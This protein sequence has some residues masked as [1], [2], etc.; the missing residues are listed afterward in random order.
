MRVD[1]TGRLLS[2]VAGW[3]REDGHRFRGIVR[4]QYHPK[5]VLAVRRVTR[6]LGSN[7][8]L[9]VGGLKDFFETQGHASGNSAESGSAPP[10]VKP[11]RWRFLARWF[12]GTAARFD[13]PMIAAS[14]DGRASALARTTAV[15]QE[16]SP[17]ANA[18][19]PNCWPNAKES[20]SRTDRRAI[21]PQN[22]SGSRLQRVVRLVGSERRPL[23]PRPP[24]SVSQET[25][26]DGLRVLCLSFRSS[27]GPWFYSCRRL[28]RL[29]SPWSSK[30]VDSFDPSKSAPT[31]PDPTEGEKGSN[32]AR[33]GV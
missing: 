19:V 8:R 5:S 9:D 21:R 20:K 23:V 25:G 2:R 3:W 13:V 26:H 30:G 1:R 12:L 11:P 10:R 29:M 6:G 31:R 24:A 15:G 17:C 16:R 14:P 7:H 18:H 28:S 4:I 27:V 33:R 32:L 22:R